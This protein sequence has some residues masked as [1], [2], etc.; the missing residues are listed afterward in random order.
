MSAFDTLSMALKNL[1]KRKLRTFLTVLGVI[2]GS[3]AI[4]IMISLGLAIN[5]SFEDRM[6]TTPNATTIMIYN[7]EVYNGQDK[8]SPAVDDAALAKIA[9]IP[10]VEAVTP[11]LNNY[12]AVK[13]GR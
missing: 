11:W 13:A 8:V 10:D 1:Y 5:K 12:V 2:V 9:Q 4:I 7:W 3:C 6:M